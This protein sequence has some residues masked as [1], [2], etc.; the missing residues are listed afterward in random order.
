MT[1]PIHG[2]EAAPDRCW[3]CEHDTGARIA[4]QACGVDLPSPPSLCSPCMDERA[5]HRHRKARSRA[6][7]YRARTTKESTR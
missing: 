5:T 4:C 7:E 2:D 6:A 3:T 1:C